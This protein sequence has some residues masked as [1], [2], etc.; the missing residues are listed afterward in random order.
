MAAVPPAKWVFTQHYQRILESKECLAGLYSRDTCA[1]KIVRA[2]I[3]PRSQLL[4]I[5]TRGHVHAVPT[6]LL[7]IM[8]MQHSAFRAHDIGAR[9]FSVLN[10]FCARHDKALFAPLEDRPLIFAEQLTLLHYRAMAAEAYQPGEIKKRPLPRQSKVRIERSSPRK[11]L[12]D[13]SR[14]L[15]CCRGS[16]GRTEG[17]G[18]H[19]RKSSISTNPLAYRSF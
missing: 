6:R 16:R 17:N 2:H 19:P 11:V 5:A 4:Q 9:E 8:Q 1:G 15:A 10:C 13:I 14:Q 3:I 18:G 7:S 12:L